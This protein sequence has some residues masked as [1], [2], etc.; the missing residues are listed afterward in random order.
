M[1]IE[2]WPQQRRILIV[3][4]MTHLWIPVSLF[5]QQLLSLPDGLVSR[6]VMVVEIEVMCRLSNMDFH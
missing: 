1:L 5:P 2:G 6:A 3:Q 4:K